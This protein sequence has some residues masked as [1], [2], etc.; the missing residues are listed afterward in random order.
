MAGAARGDGVINWQPG[1]GNCTERAGKRIRSEHGPGRNTDPV[2][3]R[4]RSEHGPG[5]NTDPVGMRTRSEHEPD[6][7]RTPSERGPRRVADSAAC[8]ATEDWLRTKRQREIPEK[9]PK[10]RDIT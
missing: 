4:I 3:T 6:R 7:E 1:M 9:G 10:H 5:R 8:A 2:G